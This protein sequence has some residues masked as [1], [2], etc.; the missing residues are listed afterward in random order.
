MSSDKVKYVL[1]QQQT[2]DHHCHWPGCSV[3]VP[4]AM[5]GCRMHW[6]RLPIIIRHG[7]WET[8]RPG[9]ETNLTPSREYIKAAQAAQ[10]WIK[11]YEESL[12]ILN[13]KETKT[14]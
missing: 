9:Q 14:N 10:N 1:G 6:F 13:G 11:Q 3:Q 2:R 8:F 4:P 5:W 12:T 7:I